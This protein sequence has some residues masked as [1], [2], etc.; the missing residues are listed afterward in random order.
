[1]AGTGAGSC[2]KEYPAHRK[3]CFHVVVGHFEFGDLWEYHCA[4]MPSLIPAA[5]VPSE[6]D[7][8][9]PWVWKC[10]ECDGA[11]DG[12]TIRLGQPTRDQISHVNLEFEMHCRQDHPYLVPVVLLALPE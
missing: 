3:T 11:F 6:G 10:S 1:M 2:L 7:R 4:L 9:V 8:E 12:G 5:F